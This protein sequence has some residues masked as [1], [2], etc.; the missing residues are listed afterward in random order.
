MNRTSTLA[1][2]GVRT[3]TAAEKDVIADI[4]QEVTLEEGLDGG[5]MLAGFVLPWQRL[6]A[7]VG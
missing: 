1:P 7:R 6:F 4:F 3:D 5:E 2:P